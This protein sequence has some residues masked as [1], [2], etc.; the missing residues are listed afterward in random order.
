MKS[1]WGATAAGNTQKELRLIAHSPY[2]LML[3]L[4]N[5]FSAVYRH[6]MQVSWLV[7][8][9]IPQILPDLLKSV[10]KFMKSAPHI[11]WRDRA[12]LSPASL[13]A[14]SRENI[15][16]I[17]NCNSIINRRD[18][19]VNECTGQKDMKKY[20]NYHVF[21]VFSHIIPFFPCQEQHLSAK[22]RFR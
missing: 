11:Q 17:F 13:L 9:H 1:N 7:D 18:F 10:D 19:F 5:W 15:K 16:R 3:C 8:R 6:F 2:S 4:L 14:P 20:P 12:G 22:G 21:A